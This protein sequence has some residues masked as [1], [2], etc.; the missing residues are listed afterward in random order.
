MKFK[1]GDEVRVTAFPDSSLVGS[2]CRIIYVDTISTYTKYPYRV[3]GIRSS[4]QN[5]GRTFDL[6]MM[7]RELAKEI[8]KGQQLLFPFMSQ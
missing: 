6:P 4:G 1:I 8:T 5:K 3:K 7:E 2:K